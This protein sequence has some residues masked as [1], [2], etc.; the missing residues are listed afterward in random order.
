MVWL[1]ILIKAKKPLFLQRLFF[2]IAEGFE[3]HP[4]TL[5]FT[6]FRLAYVLQLTELQ[7]TM[8]NLLS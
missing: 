5:I 6:S 1:N 2:V 7:T 4:P 3:P 8:S